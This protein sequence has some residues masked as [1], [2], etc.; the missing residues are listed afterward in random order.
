LGRH[1][2]HNPSQDKQNNENKENEKNVFSKLIYMIRKLRK[3][4]VVGAKTYIRLLGYARAHLPLA[5]MVAILSITSSL[6]SVLPTQIMGLAVEEIRS[7][8]IFRSNQEA[9]SQSGVSSENPA[10]SIAPQPKSS[11]P[12]APVIRKLSNYISQNWMPNLNP[13]I[14]AFYAMA[15]VFLILNLTTSIISAIHGVASTKLGQTL[16][17]DMRNHLYQHIQ[18]LSLRF[19]EDR[20]TGDIMSRIVNDVN[21]LQSVIVGPVI[22]FVQDFL[23][24]FWILYL[25][26]IWDWKLTVLSLLVGPFL[27]PATIIMGIIMRRIYRLVRQ[28]VGELNALI[29]DNL[30]G[31]RIIKGFARENYEFNRFKEKNNENRELYIKVSKI[32]AIFS[33]SLGLLM[34]IGSL[35]V[36]SYGGIKVLNGRM[37][38]GIFVVFFSYV[39]M[40]YG[41]LVGLTSFYSFIQ[42][43]LASVER[44]FE[45]L[46]T[47]PDVVDKPDAI[48]LP[49]IRGEVEF[50][51]VCF[52]Y[53]SDIQVLKNISLKA[54]P[55]QMIAFVG[56]SGA[57]KST[58]IN[59][60]ARFYDPTSG[61]ILVDGYNIK[62]VKQE[63]LRSQMGIVSQ[64]PFLFN[65]TVKSSIAYGKLGATDAEITDAAKAANAHDFIIG[66]PKGYDTIIGERGVK[67]SGGQRQRVS[68]ARAILANPRILILDEAT[69]SV[70]T[71]TEMLIQSAIQRL[72]KA[73]TTFVI[74]HRLST[75]H[76]ADLIVVLDKGNVVE[77][78][79][80]NELLA[81]NGIY[82]RF[83][84]VQFRTP[85]NNAVDEQNSNTSKED[86]SPPEVDQINDN[87]IP[88]PIRNDS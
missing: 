44:V 42:Q 85:D 65:D 53:S 81:K 43:A 70:D 86:S 77:T 11:L 20:K 50:R 64:E 71:E 34:Q 37:E 48:N 75:V 45:V 60:V 55:G 9:K 57:G 40:L 23:R 61:D 80:H 87:Q 79:T 58:S 16:V 78:G 5:F 32:S 56:P 29:Q 69:S 76:N 10:Q 24:L 33:P 31:I 68:I 30:S 8:G 22:G 39:N 36:L 7:F 27:I 51:N 19:F 63:S 74:A 17:F 67:L 21:S 25:L 72:V 52:S 59:L 13:S 1:I 62:D 84:E 4:T 47:Q 3:D 66:L 38:A 2:F 83:Y 14:V 6:I 54:Y 41:P 82:K 46:D 18:K 12:V 28:K 49:R 73:R 26:L 35:M 88:N 15:T